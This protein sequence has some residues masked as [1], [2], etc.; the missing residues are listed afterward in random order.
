MILILCVL[1][2]PLLYIQTLG[3]LETTIQRRY[4]QELDSVVI[5][6]V[7]PLLNGTTRLQDALQRNIHA[8]I[9]SRKLTSWGVEIRVTVTSQDGT[10][11]F[12]LG[13]E[14]VKSSLGGEE[15][16]AIARENYRLL[17]DGLKKNV[18]VKIAHNVSLSNLILF[19]YVF[20]SVTVLFLFY[21]RGLK[22][23]REEDLA[24]KQVIDGLTGEHRQ[25]LEK[26]S[27]LEA[28]RNG[29]SENIALMKE[30]LDE[31]RQKISATE[32]EMVE[33]LVALEER[34][35]HHQAQQD[36][37]AQEIDALKEKLLQYEKEKESRNRQSLKEGDATRKR[38]NALYKNLSIHEKAIDGFV[39]LT[40]DLQ[41]KAEETIH[42]LNGDSNLVSVK[43][44]VFGKKS[45]ET[46]FEVIFAYKGR[47]YFRKIAGNR[48]EILVIGTKLTQNKDLAFL[49]K[50]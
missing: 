24:T 7:T 38:F 50:L 49:D 46:V 4:V 48:V 17:S 26:L 11:L 30:T 27:V 43:R 10:Y 41:I 6:D 14:E 28:Q 34:I 31:E 20:L 19:V 36:L 45:R 25:Q 42:L 12:P 39:N 9:A 15:S 16:I 8:F 5:G 33:E 13:Y 23:S 2:P 40:A 21:Q 18:V 3:F 29:L 32:D 37:Q 44:K 1:L 35:S 47:L 22:R